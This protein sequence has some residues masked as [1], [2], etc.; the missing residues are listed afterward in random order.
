MSDLPI[1]KVQGAAGAPQQAK[2]A[3]DAVGQGAAFRALLES[4]ETQSKGLAQS[5]E[6]LADASGLVD[7][8]E[9]SQ[10]ALEQAKQLTDQ[11]LEAFRAN[12]Q[13]NP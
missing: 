10:R 4:L 13:R 9:Q 3:E 1:Q 2:A 5:S 11:L 12:Q 8:V 7:A 6:N